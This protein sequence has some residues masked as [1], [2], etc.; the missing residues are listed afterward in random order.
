MTEPAK[1]EVTETEEVDVS[2]FDLN[3]HIHRL[4]MDE[5]FFAAI[6]RRIDKRASFA[7]PTAGDMVKVDGNAEV[8]SVLPERV[9]VLKRTLPP[10][11]PGVPV[12]VIGL[13]VMVFDVP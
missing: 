2:A 13:I 5:P 6:S 9:A 3:I 4:L 11:R 8:V 7:L 1:S 10:P 12:K